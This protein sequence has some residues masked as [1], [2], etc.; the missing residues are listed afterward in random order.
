M[1]ILSLYSIWQLCKWFAICVVVYFLVHNGI[2]PEII[3]FLLLVR[4]GIQLLFKLVSGI[5]KIAFVFFIL[6]FLTLI[7]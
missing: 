5:I 2:S 7:F 6:C 1:K 4:L 3:C